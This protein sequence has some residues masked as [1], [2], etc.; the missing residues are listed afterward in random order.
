MTD[1][2]EATTEPTT[3]GG[4]PQ[5]Q[6]Q[7]KPSASLFEELVGEDKKY[8]TPDDLARGR[9]EADKFIDQLKEENAGM[10]DQLTEMQSKV[11]KSRTID[12]LMDLVNN[13]KTSTDE[14]SNQSEFSK[15]DI[16]KLIS[17]QIVERE[18]TKTRK[19]NR[20]AANQKVLERFENDATKAREFLGT[21]ASELGLDLKSLQE[22]AE[23]SPKAFSQ[24]LGLGDNPS[25]QHGSNLKSYQT[26][27]TES[28]FNANSERNHAYYS[29][30]RREMGTKFWHPSVQQQMMK[31]RERLGEKF[32]SSD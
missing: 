26:T 21:K 10:R 2:F 15:E 29:K 5:N 11:E 32:F 3:T 30:M 1:V 14:A 31:D 7:Q 17:E 20:E 16:E 18:T 28:S 8:K 22:M 9:L 4:E 25:P 24:L 27:N 23:T 12:E 19:T 6:E 13:A